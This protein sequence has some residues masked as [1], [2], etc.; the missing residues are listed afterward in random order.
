MGKC[1][2]E[3]SIKPFT[4]VIGR[5]LVTSG[6][7]RSRGKKVMQASTGKRLRDATKVGLSGMRNPMA[8]IGISYNGGIF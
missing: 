3:G 7:V 2:A 6:F 4:I 5:L 8:S 1:L